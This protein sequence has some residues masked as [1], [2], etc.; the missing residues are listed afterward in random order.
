MNLAVLLL[1][2]LCLIMLAG[3]LTE[4]R[5]SLA[6]YQELYG[7]FWSQVFEVTQLFNLYSSPWFLFIVLLL[8][9]SIFACVWRNAPSILESYGSSAKANHG[10]KAVK[11]RHWDV[12]HYHPAKIELLEAQLNK[13]LFSV[14]R[15]FVGSDVHLYARKGSLQKLGYLFIHLAILI[16]IIGGLVDGRAF[17]I[18]NQNDSQN[19]QQD[20]VIKRD[21]SSAP[22]SMIHSIEIAKPVKELISVEDG[23]QIVQTL[24][25]NLHIS[26][27]NE[28]YYANG[29]IRDYSATLSISPED[30][31][32][33][34]SGK[35]FADKSFKYDDYTFS[36]RGS[37]GTHGTVN[38]SLYQFGKE[39]P[40]IDNEGLTIPYQL[41]NTEDTGRFVVDGF[42]GHNAEPGKEINLSDE[43]QDIGPS[44]TYQLINKHGVPIKFDYYLEPV[45]KDG[46]D[47]HLLRASVAKSEPVLIYIPTHEGEG[48]GLNHFLS[49]NNALYSKKLIKLLVNA[50]IGKLFSTIELKSGFLHKELAAKIS[51]IIEQYAEGGREAVIGHGIEEFKEEDR[52]TATL[53]VEK[54]LDS[55][56]FMLYEQVV[57]NEKS[58]K[59]ERKSAAAESLQQDEQY[60]KELLFSVEQLKILGVNTLPV[61]HNYEQQQAVVLNISKQPGQYAVIS[62]MFILLF[63]VLLTFYVNNREYS[64]RIVPEQNTARIYLDGY[65]NR[66]DMLFNYEFNNLGDVLMSVSI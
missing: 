5:Q 65:T 53:F 9:S 29:Q 30:G 66:Q 40:T 14:S 8:L 33:T 52:E 36:L 44:M 64:I 13:R 58:G 59:V 60:M 25:F 41:S 62:G 18:F 2:T 20:N 35:I 6:Y 54:M 23:V 1:L 17:S 55:A 48:N 34:V 10:S 42:R 51:L 4:Q 61:V 28:A 39:K 32:P 38:L 49:F 43:F 16:I 15:T 26:D 63:G 46:Y 27:S 50:K 22:F 21:L 12:N 19:L 47:Y 37:S 3:T 45:I 7:P 31:G 24:P 57:L 56:L 11:S